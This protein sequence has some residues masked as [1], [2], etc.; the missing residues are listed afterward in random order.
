MDGRQLW[1]TRTFMQRVW[2]GLVFLV[3]CSGESQLETDSVSQAVTFPADSLYR[4]IVTTDPTGDGGTNGR[5]LVGDGT[6]P[7]CY[8]YSDG[9]TFFSRLRLNDSPFQAGGLAQY[10][11]SIII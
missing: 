11:W 1:P 5:D 6:R 2:F 4:P 3:A 7:A 9:Q 10:G 8:V